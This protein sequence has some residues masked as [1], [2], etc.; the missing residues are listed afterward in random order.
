MRESFAPASRRTDPASSHLAEQEI[1]KS[2]ARQRQCDIVLWCV[3][4]RNGATAKELAREAAR[5]GIKDVDSYA[6]SRRLPD[7][8]KKGLVQRGVLREC[9]VGGR[10]SV[11]WW[12]TDK[13]VSLPAPDAEAA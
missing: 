11:T 9:L 10:R 2:G 7:L 4:R 12:P 1:N 8:E 13:G 5:R 3:L 6:F